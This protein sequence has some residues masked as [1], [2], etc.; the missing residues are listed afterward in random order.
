L[1][2]G[3]TFNPFST[4]LLANKPAE[5][6]ESGLLVLV[7]EVIADTTIDPFFNSHS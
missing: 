3:E 4:A 7:H 1:L 2:Y 6:K 5:T